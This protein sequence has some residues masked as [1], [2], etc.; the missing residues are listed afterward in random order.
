VALKAVVPGLL[1]KS[2]LGGVLL[3][4]TG[5]DAVRAGY[6]TLRERFGD[7]LRGVLVQPMVPAGVET[8]VGV[9]SDP[10]FGPLVVFGAGGVVTDLL[11]DRA[12]RLAP[13]TDL[14]AAA[15]VREVRTSALLFGYRG[16][17]PADHAAVEAVLLR[18]G[19]LAEALP[20]VAELELNPLVVHPSGCVAVD[21]RVRLAPRAAADPYLRQLR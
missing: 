14:D 10:T 6:A 19:A 11:G 16:A 4:V 17:T 8:L 2:D 18:V 1:H 13:V 5:A 12:A 7:P 21:A 9:V 3:G 15:M 20:E